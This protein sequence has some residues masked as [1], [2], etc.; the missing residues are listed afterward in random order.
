MKDFN[1]LLTSFK[2]LKTK[3]KK[4]KKSRNTAQKGAN[5]EKCRQALQKLL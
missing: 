2:S 3:Q 4:K 5:Y 1:K